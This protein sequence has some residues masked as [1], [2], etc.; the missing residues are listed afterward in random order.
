MIMKLEQ[1]G[2]H[3]ERPDGSWYNILQRFQVASLKHRGLLLHAPKQSSIQI[4]HNPII[5][6][7]SNYQLFKV[8]QNHCHWKRPSIIYHKTRR[9]K[10]LET[11]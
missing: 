3:G 11:N 9:S 2:K 5:P 8:V 10:R 7:H 4:E 6:L 1:T